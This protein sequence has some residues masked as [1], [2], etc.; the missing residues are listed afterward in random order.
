MRKGLSA[1]N[2]QAGMTSSNAK[3]L[4]NKGLKCGS[5][6]KCPMPV[7]GYEKVYTSNSS[8]DRIYYNLICYD[9]LLKRILNAE[10]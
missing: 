3:A 7:K 9:L 2:A 5:E 6:K 8:F 4:E 10:C 1:C